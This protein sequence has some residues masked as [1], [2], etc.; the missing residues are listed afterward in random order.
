[1]VKGRNIEVMNK[2]TRVRHLLSCRLRLMFQNV[3]CQE[4]LFP[5]NFFITFP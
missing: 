1:M 3:Y 2:F 4:M 5:F